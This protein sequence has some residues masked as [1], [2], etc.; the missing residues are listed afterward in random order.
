[1]KAEPPVRNYDF[2]SLKIFFRI[3][4]SYIPFTLT[5]Y[6]PTTLWFKE[7]SGA[8]N[9]WNSGTDRLPFILDNCFLLISE[10]IFHLAEKFTNWNGLKTCRQI[11]PLPQASTFSGAERK[12]V[13]R[14]ANGRD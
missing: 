3:F 14:T 2:Q 9:S 7:F 13:S 5:K 10:N 11:A 12:K 4:E 8:R 1:L 6:L